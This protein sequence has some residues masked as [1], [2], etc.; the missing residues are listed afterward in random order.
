MD[1]LGDWRIGPTSKADQIEVS[2]AK[3]A[4]EIPVNSSSQ[5]TPTNT[6]R[7]GQ[8]GETK[9]MSFSVLGN[10]D[11]IWNVN[12]GCTDNTRIGYIGNQSINQSMLFIPEY[13]IHIQIMLSHSYAIKK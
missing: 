9:W 7:N 13:S 12:K 4:R 10:C 1:A 11:Q 2:S 6:T 5:K 8:Q 3:S